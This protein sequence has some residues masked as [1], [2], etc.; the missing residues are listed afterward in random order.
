MPQRLRRLTR[1]PVLAKTVLSASP[2][3][4]WSPPEPLSNE[5][6]SSL[7][8]CTLGLRASQTPRDASIERGGPIGAR[9]RR[10]PCLAVRSAM[11]H[12]AQPATLRTDLMLPW[13][14]G[15]LRR[16]PSQSPGRGFSLPARSRTAR[17]RLGP[18]NA[19][20]AAVDAPRK[21]GRRGPGALPCQLRRPK[22]RL[23]RLSPP[24]TPSW[25]IHRRMGRRSIP[26]P[27]HPQRPRRT[28]RAGRSA[29]VAH[30]TAAAG[31]PQPLTTRRPPAGSVTSR[32]ASGRTVAN[33]RAQGVSR[34]GLWGSA[35]RCR[36]TAGSMISQSMTC[37]SAFCTVRVSPFQSAGA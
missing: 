14:P 18:A 27:E 13:L 12:A 33:A 24:R 29:A 28:V 25:E 23:L 21:K 9:P 34:R 17:A 30:A 35:C 10:V 37:P 8:T 15:Q 3:W 11:S 26:N 36:R 32:S 5:S 4:G 1:H 16:Q 6:K 7:S 20:T 31:A 2:E 19:G 22:P